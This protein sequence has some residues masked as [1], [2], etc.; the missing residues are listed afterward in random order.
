MWSPNS[1]RQEKNIVFYKKATQP[2]PV[3]VDGEWIKAKR[4]EESDVPPLTIG[5]IGKQIQQL[6]TA[7]K[8]T[9]K[10]VATQ[11]NMDIR[12]LQKWEQCSKTPFNAAD[13]AKINKGLGVAGTPNA[14]KAPRRKSS[15]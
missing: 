9:Q 15:L 8:L 13:L 2:K 11:G 1:E 14:I 5:D 4:L 7:K 6:R 3:Q 10:Q 12:V